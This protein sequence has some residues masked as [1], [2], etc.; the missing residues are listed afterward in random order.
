MSHFC[1][2]DPFMITKSWKLISNV[3]LSSY[4]KMDYGCINKVIGRKVGKNFWGTRSEHIVG[5]AASLAVADHG[6]VAIFQN[7]L[8]KAFSFAETPA[9]FI[10]HTFFSIY[11]GVILYAA[12]TSKGFRQLRSFFAQLFPIGLLISYMSY[13]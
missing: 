7:Y 9:A 2:R 13:S 5:V 3:C 6:S 11:F 4:I 12:G 1:D 10:A 8:G